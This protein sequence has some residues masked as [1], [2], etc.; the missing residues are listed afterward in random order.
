MDI[1]KI[2]AIM[3]KKTNPNDTSEPTVDFI[4]AED[5]KANKRENFEALI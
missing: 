4:C 2:V 3:F 5:F 1:E